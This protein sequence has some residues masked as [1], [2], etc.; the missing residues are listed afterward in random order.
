MLVTC[1]VTII[2]PMPATEACKSRSNPSP[3]AETVHAMLA[4]PPGTMS[5][6][7]ALVGVGDVSVPMATTVWAELNPHNTPGLVD[8]VCNAA[9]T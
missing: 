7:T 1:P 5:P 9:L 8:E 2:V 3:L 6:S 4:F